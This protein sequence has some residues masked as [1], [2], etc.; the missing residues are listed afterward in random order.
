MYLFKRKQAAVV[1]VMA[2]IGTV[3]AAAA[4]A[5]KKRNSHFIMVN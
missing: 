5:G 1:A 2:A 4:M 3:A